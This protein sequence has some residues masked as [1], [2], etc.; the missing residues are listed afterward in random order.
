MKGDSASMLLKISVVTILFAFV[1]ANS[2]LSQDQSASGTASSC[3]ATQPNGLGPSPEYYGVGKMAVYI[4]TGGTV[5]FQPGGGGFVD[6]DGSLGIKWPWWHGV[7]GALTIT[8]RT[9][10]TRPGSLPTF[11]IFPQAGCWEVTGTV[12]NENLTFVTRVE[13]IGDGPSWRR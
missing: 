13:K 9:F 7:P 3:K 10:L 2:A 11:L 6:T 1:A 4:Y 12:G 8:G 5:V